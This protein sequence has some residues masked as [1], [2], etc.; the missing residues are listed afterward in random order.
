MDEQVAIDCTNEDIIKYR[1]QANKTQQLTQ[2]TRNLTKEVIRYT[3]SRKEYEAACAKLD[4]A[5]NKL[6]EL[7]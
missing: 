6:E 1:E 5:L 3:S 7:K 2:M 4:R